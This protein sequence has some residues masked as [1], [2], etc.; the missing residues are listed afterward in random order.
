MS[1][2]KPPAT[3]ALRSQPKRGNSEDVDS[4]G[5]EADVELDQ[6]SGKKPITFHRFNTKS[7]T[8]LEA[9]DQEINNEQKIM[10]NRALA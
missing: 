2:Q 6:N 3:P 5:Q 9:C 1:G 8:G 10:I 4:A 7:K